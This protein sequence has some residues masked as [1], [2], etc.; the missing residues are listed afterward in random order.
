MDQA[1]VPTLAMRGVSKT[2]PG[3]KAL[4]DVQLEAWGGEVRMPGWLRRMLRR[5]AP[6]GDTPEGAH[7]ARKPK[8][9]RSVAKNADRAAMGAVSDLY[10]EDHH[11]RG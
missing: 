4:N 3:V 5:P 9:E 8:S 11:K 6:P 7:E 1:R 2:F 10:R